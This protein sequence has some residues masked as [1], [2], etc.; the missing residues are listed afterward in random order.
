MEIFRLLHPRYIGIGAASTLLVLL[1]L[2]GIGLYQELNIVLTSDIYTLQN[3]LYTITLLYWYP[4]N[5]LSLISVATAALVSILVGIQAMLVSYIKQARGTVSIKRTSQ[6][7]IVSAVFVS[8]GMGCAACGSVIAL[9][10][11]SLFGIGLSA[12][13]SQIM[14]DVFMITAVAILLYTNFKLYRQAQ[15]PLACE[16]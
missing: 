9:S 2:L 12:S 15:Y 4:L 1:V 8:L 11:L 10:I 14:V 5:Q 13:I 16:I 3:K 6:G 7:S